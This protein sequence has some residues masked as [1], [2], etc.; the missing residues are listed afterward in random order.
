MTVRSKFDQLVVA[1]RGEIDDVKVLCGQLRDLAERLGGNGWRADSR[2]AAS[3]ATE[4]EDWVIDWFGSQR[5]VAS[6]SL[7]L[8]DSERRLA[9]LNA[10]RVAD[11]FRAADAIECE[12]CGERVWA[13]PEPTGGGRTCCWGK[14][15]EVT[16]ARRVE[17]DDRTQTLPA[18]QR[19]RRRG[20]RGTVVPR[21]LGLLR[22]VLHD[23]PASLPVRSRRSEI[24]AA[25]ASRRRAA[26]GLLHV[27]R[28]SDR[29]VFETPKRPQTARGT[30][31]NVLI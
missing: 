23:P 21:L 2:L 22:R 6:L 8:E 11:S 16:S 24:P 19:N 26:L 30:A 28:R 20:F 7:R 17:R 3:A 10:R 31:R 29:H 18:E 9:R 14:T 4:L 1:K 13:I 12:H 27:V 25:M 5:L 15:G